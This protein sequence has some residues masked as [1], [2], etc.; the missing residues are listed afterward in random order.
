M[1][2]DR[3]PE[4]GSNN[5]LRNVDTYLPDYTSL[6]MTVIFMLTIVRYNSHVNYTYYV[7]QL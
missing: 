7:T 5:F 6:L 2:K 4:D 3:R 1:A